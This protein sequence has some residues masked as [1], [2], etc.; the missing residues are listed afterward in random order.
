[1]NV[2]H[3]SLSQTTNIFDLNHLEKEFGYKG[4]TKSKKGKAKSNA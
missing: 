3:D 1:M 2:D 4:S